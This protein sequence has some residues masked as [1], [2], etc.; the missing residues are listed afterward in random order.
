MR[1]KKKDVS[2]GKIINFDKSKINKLSDLIQDMYKEE[3]PKN[4]IHNFQKKL[5][6]TTFKI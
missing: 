5:T 6:T 3:A 1:L 4:P 2:G